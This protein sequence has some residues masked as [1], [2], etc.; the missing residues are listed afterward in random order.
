MF[1]FAS[2][3]NVDIIE[4]ALDGIGG[5]HLGNWQSVKDL[6]YLQKHN[7]THVVTALP[8]TMC[9]MEELAK[10]SIKQHQVPCEDSPNFQIFPLLKAVADFIEA[11][12]REG[13]VLVHCAAGISRSTTCLIAYFIRHRKMSTE[14]ALTYIRQK[15]SCASPNYGFINALKEFETAVFSHE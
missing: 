8:K 13:N 11:G 9:N 12:V 2:Y 7:I 4:P 1:I 5:I 15:R 14:A 6:N 10:F 3:K